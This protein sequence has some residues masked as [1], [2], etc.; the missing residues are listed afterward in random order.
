MFADPVSFIVLVQFIIMIDPENGDME[1]ITESQIPF[2][3][4]NGPAYRFFDI[5]IGKIDW[6]IFQTRMFPV[7]DDR[8]NIFHILTAFQCQPVRQI[9]AV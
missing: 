4:V 6:M 8:G 5:G 1:H 3:S 2:R 7:D 9:S